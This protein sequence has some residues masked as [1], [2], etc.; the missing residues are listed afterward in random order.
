MIINYTVYTLVNYT[1]KHDRSC[2]ASA[3]VF[4]LATVGLNKSMLLELLLEPSMAIY[5]AHRNNILIS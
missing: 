4:V 5:L 3:E 2:A 1:V